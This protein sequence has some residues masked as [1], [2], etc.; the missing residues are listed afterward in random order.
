VQFGNV[1]LFCKPIEGNPPDHLALL[2][3]FQEPIKVM[4]MATELYNAV[5]R[6]QG[7]AKDGSGAILLRWTD[8]GMTVSAKSTENGE[9][10][11]EIPVLSASAPGRVAVNVPYLR[12]YL[13]GKDGFVTMGMAEGGGAAIFHYGTTPVVAIMP[14]AVKWDEDQPEQPDDKEQPEPVE[15]EDSLEPEGGEDEPPETKD[16]QESEEGEMETQETEPVEL[17]ASQEPVGEEEK[18]LETE[19]VEPE[20]SQEKKTQKKRYQRKKKVVEAN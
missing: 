9:S 16:Y 6:L 17:E 8:T 2:N 4:L 11:A 20:A 18:P 7:I 13:S 14:M 1:T 10:K 5:R 12:D 3:N 15:T 19:A